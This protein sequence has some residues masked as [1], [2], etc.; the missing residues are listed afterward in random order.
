MW[1][2]SGQ[3]TLKG[4]PFLALFLTNL[5]R[6]RV[7]TAQKMKFCIKNF[8]FLRILS[9]LLK[10]SLMENFIFCSVSL[11]IWAIVIL[12]LT[13]T[14]VIGCKPCTTPI[15]RQAGEFIT[16][17][18]WVTCTELWKR[19]LYFLKKSVHN[20]NFWQKQGQMLNQVSVFICLNKNHRN[21]LFLR[22]CILLFSKI[23]WND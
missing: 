4:W 14:C 18:I 15:Q 10:K 13:S 9:D 20:L 2:F 6:F 1:P 11:T 12:S 7:L 22:N 16:T 23:Q 19:K 3:Q 5:N 8:S 21:C 17:W